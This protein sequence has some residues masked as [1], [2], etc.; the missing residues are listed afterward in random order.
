MTSDNAKAEI[1]NASNAP[2]I[3]EAGGKYGQQGG[4]FQR[5]WAISRMIELAGG[6][7]PDFLLLFET[8]QDL[9]EL[10]S[11]DAPTR[12]RIYQLKMLKAGEW[13][14]KS[15]TGLPAKPRKKRGSTEMTEPVPFTKT[16]IGKLA[17]ALAE[18]NQIEAEGIFVSNSG[19]SAELEAGSTAGSVP[20]CAFT[21][22][23]KD[24]RDEISPELAKLKKP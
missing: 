3:F 8:I 11:S 13:T 7:T 5:Y 22:L 9:L 18:L 4:D 15:L 20:F 14:W 16:P 24:R 6:D 19:C 12:A 17:A 21:E 1:F 2:D 10:D 23:C